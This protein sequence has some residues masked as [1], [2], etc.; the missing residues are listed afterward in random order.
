[1]TSGLL[2]GLLVNLNYIHISGYTS[3]ITAQAGGVYNVIC[4]KLP[5]IYI[6]DCPKVRFISIVAESVASNINIL[7]IFID[8]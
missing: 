5:A 3:G 1:M 7:V 2:Q 4:T 6:L 8:V